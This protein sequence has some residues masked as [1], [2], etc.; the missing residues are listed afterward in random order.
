MSK[1]KMMFYVNKNNIC[2]VMLFNKMLAWR[3][4]KIHK[5]VL[6]YPLNY[7]LQ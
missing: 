4:K 3:H 6:H 7:Y 1:H 2:K 5:I